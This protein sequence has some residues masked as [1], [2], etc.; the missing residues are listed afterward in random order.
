[1]PLEVPGAAPGADNIHTRDRD[2][3]HA[4]SSDGGTAGRT[5]LKAADTGTGLHTIQKV[6]CLHLHYLPHDTWL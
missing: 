2:H 1:M 6:H 3:G 5:G 4:V